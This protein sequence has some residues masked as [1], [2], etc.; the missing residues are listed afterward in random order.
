MT[1]KWAKQALWKCS[2]NKTTVNRKAGYSHDGKER[3]LEMWQRN[4]N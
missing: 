2:A 4:K 3:L 1:E